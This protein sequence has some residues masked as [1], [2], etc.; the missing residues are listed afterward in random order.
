MWEVRDA[1]EGEVHPSVRGMAAGEMDA[2]L[3]LVLLMLRDPALDKRL[4][5]KLAL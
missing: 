5:A 3:G 4:A 1:E 2:A